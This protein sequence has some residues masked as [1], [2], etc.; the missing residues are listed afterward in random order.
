M[1]NITAGC[2]RAFRRRLSRRCCGFGFSY[3][4]WI[5]LSAAIV[6]LWRMGVSRKNLL[7]WETAAQS[8]RKKRSVGA[9]YLNMW[10]APAAGL[11][12]VI[13]STGIFAKTVG[14]LWIVAPL[15]ALALTLP[16][17]PV[18]ELPADKK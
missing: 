2:S 10:A 8:E 12:L 3:E 15:A 4:A 18:R 6:S 17:K 13:F 16:A 14:L 5:V 7:E 1:S 11:A 9:Y